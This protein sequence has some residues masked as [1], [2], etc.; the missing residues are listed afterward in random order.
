MESI[1]VTLPDGSE[2][3]VPKGT[4]PLEVAESISPRLA[5]AA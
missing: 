4:T 1:R 5:K 3:Q 2:K